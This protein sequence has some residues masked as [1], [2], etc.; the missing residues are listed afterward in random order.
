MMRLGSYFD[1]LNGVSF[2]LEMFALLVL[3]NDRKICNGKTFFYFYLR[4]SF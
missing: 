4:L 2:R 1:T 3:F